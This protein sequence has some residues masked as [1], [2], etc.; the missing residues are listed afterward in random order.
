M[1]DFISGNLK[2][3]RFEFATY[4]YEAYLGTEEFI[5]TDPDV[6]S[7]MLESTDTL[8]SIMTIVNI[9]IKLGFDVIIIDIIC[10]STKIVEYL[11]DYFE[12]TGTYFET[13]SY[14]DKLCFGKK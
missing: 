4:D 6:F 7:F 9:A 2:T 5:E 11:L 3:S 14:E 12:K 10:T 13:K 1:K 8:P